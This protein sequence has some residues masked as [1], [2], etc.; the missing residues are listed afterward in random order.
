MHSA[1]INQI[2]V[3]NQSNTGFKSKLD[4]L[5][6]VTK[7]DRKQ[8]Q[9]ASQESKQGIQEEND[10]IQ[11]IPYRLIGSPVSVAGEVHC[12]SLVLHISGKGWYLS[13]LP[14]RSCLSAFRHHNNSSTSLYFLQS[15]ASQRFSQWLVK[16]FLIV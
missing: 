2:Q 14:E 1:V 9:G 11:F 4:V 16:A 5:D 12:K 3:Y 15:A 13:R 10:R 8:K 6:L 7:C